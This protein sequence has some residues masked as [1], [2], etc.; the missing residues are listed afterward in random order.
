VRVMSQ[1]FSL[2]RKRRSGTTIAEIVYTFA[3]LQEF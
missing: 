2:S 3:K 1:F